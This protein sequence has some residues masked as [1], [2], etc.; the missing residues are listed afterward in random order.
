M[1]IW[2]DGQCFQTAS[3][4]RG[5]GRYCAEFVTALGHHHSDLEIHVSLN[6]SMPDTAVTAFAALE[7]LI[8]RNNIHVWQGLTNE[9]EAQ[10]GLSRERRLSELALVHH[11]NCLNPDVAIS[12]SPFEG[13]FDPAVPLL[14][15]AALEVPA[16]GIFY[17]AIPW[18]FPDRYLPG[19]AV[20][21]F[22]R[23][24]LFSYQGFN[25][26]LAIS[27]FSQTEAELLLQ[28]KACVNISAGVSRDFLSHL[29]KSA[30]TSKPELSDGFI[31]Y[32]GA[33]DWRK[34]V[35]VIVEA[36]ARLP[37]EIRLNSVFALAGD[38]PGPLI[39][40]LRSLWASRGLPA[41]NFFPCGLVSDSDLVDL[42]RRA[43]VLVQPSLMEGFG[44]TALEA[45]VCGVPVLAA[46][47]GA[48]PEI[49]K[50]EDWLFDPASPDE[51][52]SRLHRVLTDTELSEKVAKRK[53]VA[54]VEFTWE[55]TAKIAHSEISAT[56]GQ[57]K[58]DVQRS[59]SE[60]RQAIAELAKPL[61]IEVDVAAQIMALAEL[62]KDA[63]HR[64]L[65]D[66]T[67]TI[68]SQHNSGIQR[69]VRRVSQ[70]AP[71]AAESRF[72]SVHVFYCNDV[73]G[74]FDTHG[75][76]KDKPAKTPG[77]RL[78]LGRNDHIFALDS[79]WEFHEQQAD[80]YR[81]ARLRGA[82][83]TS[84]IY[85]TVPL[86]TSG[87][88]AR[89]M[90]DVFTSWLK[91]ALQYST[92]LMCISKAVADEMVTL[93][94]AMQFPRPMNVGYW[95][96]GADLDGSGP[97]AAKAIKGQRFKSFL[98][99]G[100]VEPRKGY[101]VALSA[102]EDLWSRG[103]DV[104]LTIVGRYGWGANDIA[105]RIRDNPEF[106]RKLIWHAEATDQLLKDCYEQSDALIA[107]S[108]A[109]GFGLPIVEAGHLGKPVL[110]SDL[111]VF[112]EV[113]TGSNGVCFF[114]VGDEQDLA[115]KIMS[116]SAG[117]GEFQVS[118]DGPR[119]HWPDWSESTTQL[120]D[121][122]LTGNWYRT[123]QPLVTE[124]FVSDNDID[125]HDLRSPVPEDERHY[126]L[127][128]VSDPAIVD[129]PNTIKVT[130]AVTNE[131]KAVWPGKGIKGAQ[132]VCLSYHVVGKDGEML[133]FDNLRT[134]VPLLLPPGDT[135]Y[136]AI[137]IDAR[138]V[139]DGAAYLD[140]SL[141]QERVAWWGEPQRIDLKLA[142]D[143]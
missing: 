68:H 90:P 65:I 50:E 120:L 27:K 60:K 57:E 94:T 23:R 110:A 58:S 8:G 83:I 77:N 22:Y 116:L 70:H 56:S 31:L 129:D 89:G 11:V 7:P 66:A 13:Q 100:T 78:V 106:G 80:F 48:L 1:R 72:S 85:D 92:G 4:N 134:E 112:R 140:I 115:E 45:L 19:E 16:I 20:K 25:S 119:Q 30:V 97:S 87:F 98:M 137:Y 103:A 121:K 130:V 21:E 69:V 71:V 29:A 53:S 42:Y 123:Y 113:S 76:L 99:V 73:S 32:V 43:A 122:L 105:R 36:I 91:M 12:A 93:L 126:S 84:C 96:L 86:S 118:S 38:H 81:E 41:E 59:L 6:A 61:E 63:G 141:L 138:W 64:L 35:K 44:L 67:S 79:S 51:L 124:A 15:N 74:A 135:H 3:R 33:L 95:Q 34:N 5:I 102:F 131:S 54:E 108:F 127:R 101:N 2:F 39:D 104:R 40:E 52:C 14:P 109:E 111:D 49:V 132:P 107:A 117:H 82:R 18:R 139:R 125:S 10:S 9:G 62:P 55:K 136:M 47:A 143:S 142:T 75:N 17:D 26:V 128:I 88:C 24:R 37:D 46:R 114:R 133:S 28:P